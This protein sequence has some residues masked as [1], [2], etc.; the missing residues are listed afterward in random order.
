MPK[1]R[2]LAFSDGV[3]AVIITIMVLELK[4]PHGTDLAAVAK[5]GPG[6]ASYV[7]SFI[8]VAI[9][10]NNHHHLMHT[11]TTVNGALLWANT[12]LL[13]WLSLVPLASA[14]MGENDFASLPT[15]AYGLVML[16]PAIAYYIL[17]RTIIAQQG[18]GSILAKAIGRDLKGKASP[19]LFLIAIPLAF[20]SPWIS[21]AIYVL[22][23]LIWLVPDQK[24]E[25]LM[26]GA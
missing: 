15:A 18:P 4:A 12:H 6:F 26:G 23:A 9:Y 19:L 5:L 21:G 1:E 3:I 14:W 24:I 25:R 2:L 20:V 10:W 11:V 7:I 16:M 13:F 17:Q 22:V 8:Y